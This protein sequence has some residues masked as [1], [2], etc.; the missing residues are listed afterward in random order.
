MNFLNKSLMISAD[1]IEAVKDIYW[2]DAIRPA[3]S[4]VIENGMAIISI[5]GL[6]T[7]RS[8]L[9]LC[10]TTSYD[11]IFEAFCEAL[12]DPEVQ[13]IAFDIDSPGGEVSGLF[14]LVDYIFDSRSEKPI[15]AYINDCA[16]SAAYAI[17]S[18][19]SKVFVTR[20]SMAGSIGVIAIHSDISEAEKKAGIKYTTV[21]AG[22]KKNDLSPHEPIA[23]GA[24]ADLQGEVDRIYRMFVET[25][26]RNRNISE[27]A[28]TSTE[29]GIFYG[30]NAMEMN[31]ADEL[32]CVPLRFGGESTKIGDIVM[33]GELEMKP[34]TE[35]TVEQTM[36][37]E[38]AVEVYKAEILEISKLC[39][40]AHAEHKI[41]DFIIQGLTPEQVK[42]KLLDSMNSKEEIT[43][44]IYQKNE[45]AENPV[46]A[47]AKQRAQISK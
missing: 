46:I 11:E 6:L 13:S 43:S 25:V 41:T 28:I 44:S 15:Y 30:E 23:D 12:K 38:N 37:E 18:A 7:K 19:A 40:L 45:K 22:S 17:A 47:A 2:I 27:E 16:C 35:E 24:I 3:K 5:H 21:F 32:V 1:I 39:K 42:E 14:D 36:A 26:A 4:Y 9:F 33:K 29:A 20:T 10:D 31:L 8:E 34:E